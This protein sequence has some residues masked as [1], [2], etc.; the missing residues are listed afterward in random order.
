MSTN[1]NSYFIGEDIMDPY[2][3]AFKVAKGLSTNFPLRTISTPI[4][5]LGIAGVGNGLALCDN[6]VIVEF[7]FAD[8]TF[9]AFDQIINFAAKTRTMYGQ[10]LDHSILFRCPVGG[11]R[12]CG[13][14]H[15]S[16]NSKIFY[17][18]S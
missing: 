15:E 14:T 1:K 6:K 5:E 7:M 12:G 2:G 17:W 8:F 18:D 4:S 9:L 10:L 16:I 13:P 3:G 11:H